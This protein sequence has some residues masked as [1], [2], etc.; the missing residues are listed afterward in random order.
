MKRIGIYAG[1]FDPV[2][3]GHL[4]FA[5]VALKECKLDKVFFLVEPT[6]RRKQGVKAF[7]HRVKMVQ[8]ALKGQPHFG[9]VVTEQQ[10]FSV[11][12][13]VPY[14][15]H[16]FKNTHLTM[17]MG[18]DV[19]EHLTSWPH[20]ERLLQNI[21]IVVGARHNSIA[22]VGNILKAIVTTRGI[23]FEYT[24]IK[25]PDNVVNSSHVRQLFRKGEISKDV[26]VSVARYI[27]R[28]RLYAPDE[29]PE[30]SVL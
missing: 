27:K 23:P 10:Q 24:V 1:T 8:L 17:L 15:M 4:E 30:E 16:R 19:L 9:V 3:N 11:S 21:E 14:L 7:Q 5:R 12:E 13:T 20:V 2:H 22:H 18:E 28:E 26:P 29:S 25:T 6:P